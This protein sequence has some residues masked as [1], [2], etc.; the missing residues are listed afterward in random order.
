MLLELPTKHNTPEKLLKRLYQGYLLESWT[1]GRTFLWAS[2]RQDTQRPDSCPCCKRL[3]VK[4]TI[5]SRR[6]NISRN[7]LAVKYSEPSIYRY[8]THVKT[9]KPNMT[10]EAGRTKKR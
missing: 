5:P 4:C 3:G 9:A 2:I 1:H 10:K 6:C 8:T 7:V